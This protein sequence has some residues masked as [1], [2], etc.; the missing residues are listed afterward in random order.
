MESSLVLNYAEVFDFFKIRMLM[1]TFPG[2]LLCF[3]SVIS[4]DLWG[5]LHKKIKISRQKL[6][7]LPDRYFQFLKILNLKEN[8]LKMLFVHNK[9]VLNLKKR[10]SSNRLQIM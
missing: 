6:Q 5:F 4:V 9:L 7:R 8:C 2:K 1:K 10:N 3:N